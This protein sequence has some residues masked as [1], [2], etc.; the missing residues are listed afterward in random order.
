[1]DNFSFGI[2]FTPE[3]LEKYEILGTLGEGGMGQVYLGLQKSLNRKVAIKFLSGRVVMSERRIAK[4][5]N[6]ARLCAEIVWRRLAR[7]GVSVPQED[8]CVEIVG[9]GACLP[10]IMEAPCEPPEVVLRMGMRSRDRRK[11]A[12][13]GM[14][15]APLIT[16]G[17]PGITGFAGGRPKPQEIVAY[18]PALLEK[19]AVDP[20]VRVS[21]EEV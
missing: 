19:S 20:Y 13:F 8:R 12:R 4:F 17:P 15:L 7:A 9:A 21:V 16:S 6:E 1:M 5:N 11:V 3:F 2:D 10:G 18:W 14:E